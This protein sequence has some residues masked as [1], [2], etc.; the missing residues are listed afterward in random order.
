VGE[1]LV[2]LDHLRVKA[3]LE[4]VADALVE[5]VEPL[6]MNAVDAVEGTRNRRHRALYDDVDVV[7]HQAVRGR[8]EAVF[9]Q[10]AREQHQEESVVILVAEDRAPVDPAHGDVEDSERRQHPSWNTRHL[11]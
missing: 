11:L 9:P 5:L 8:D 3:V 7:R 4:Q 6:R 10:Q 1:V 2:T